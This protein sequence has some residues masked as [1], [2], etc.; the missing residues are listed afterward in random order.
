MTRTLPLLI[1]LACCAPAR[2]KERSP[3]YVWLEPEW[4]EGVKGSFT[5][6]TG[7]AKPTGAWGVAGPGVAAEWSQG[8]ESEWNSMGAPAAET[9]ARCERALVVPRAG[10][11]RLWVRYVD[12]RRKTEPFRV[13]IQQ[14]GK[15]VL[16]GEL[17]LKDVVPPGDEYQLYWG[18]S[19]AWDGVEG[20]LTEGPA[21]LALTIDKAGQGWRQ[22]DA[23]LLTDDLKYVPAGREKPAFAYQAGFDLR[24][25]AGA[26]WR[27]S[28]KGLAVGAGWKRQPPAGRDFAM[29]TGISPDPK[30]WAK[31]DRGR[32]TLPDVLYH[33]SP[34]A[35]IKDRFHKQFAGRKDVPIISWPKL[36]PG[37]YLGDTPDLSDG[38]PVRKWLERTKTPFFILTNYASGAYTDKTGPA[39]FAALTGPL[40]GQFLGYVHGE[41]VGTGGVALPE[42]PLAKDRR[43]HVD[44]LAGRLRKEQAA[45]WGK[46]YK[47]AVPEG[48]WDRGIS[49]LSADCIALAHLLHDAGSRTVG[50]EIDATNVHAPMRIAFARGAARQYGG[51]WVNY[52]S[53]NFGDSCNYFTQE[54]VVP[55]GAK[56]WFHSRYAVTDGVSIA[57][58][59]KLY[60]LN[61]LGGAAAVYWEQ[62][63]TNQYLL[64][65]PG[66]H[67]IQ[68]SPFGRATEDFQAFVDRLPD[69]GEPYT[70]VALLLSYGHGYDRVNYRCKMLN[71]FQEDKHDLELRELFN[72][73]WHPAG[74]LE[75]LPAS[76]DVQSMPAGAYGDIF[77]VLVDRP[78]RARAI[79]DYPV[80]WAAG[81]VRLTGP[82]QPVL[83]EY[84]QKGGTL[85]LNIEAAR[86]LPEKLLGLRPTGKYVRAEEWSPDGGNA[87]PTTPY[88]VARVDLAGARAL[89]WAG[90][91]Q[92]LIARHAV[93]A[94]AVIVTLVP[95]LIGL[96]ERAHPSIPFLLNGL[97]ERLLP[98][99]V[100]LADGRRPRGEV[101]Y[102]VN[103]TKDG[104]LVSLINPRGIDKT[105]N[106]IARVDRRAGV[107][108]V[109]STALP[110]R[111]A[112]EMTGPAGLAVRRQG[113][114]A[115]VPVR[116]PAG[117][118]RV[119]YLRAP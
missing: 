15:T 86:G 94:G 2:A 71:V 11:Y 34:P 38:S 83:E 59:R 68:L 37:F 104:Y 29:W 4:F 112:E 28:G 41:A 55:R 101:M 19:F 97:T 103:R 21:R 65:A 46:I 82:F 48:H 98:V 79:L 109:L 14:G 8:G 69:R 18:F 119:V 78:A 118:V 12:H 31:Q 50:Y 3:V 25:P 32:L 81:D 52:A 107:D 39:T 36:L 54:P 33:F 90:P 17:G 56:C 89:A 75:G 74:M 44:A 47:T 96:D 114:G 85:V 61:Y 1:V 102:Q 84:L 30:W 57:W 76:P 58:Y 93:G 23:L 10:K 87:R 45:A 80:V 20:T 77:D 22:V 5:Y 110:V 100:R 51:A 67:P 66:T 91:K 105:Q 92:P 16:A 99:E 88:E 64:P 9:S 42:Q 70:P 72:V 53:G 62:N 35:D 106:G 63:L 73:C 108:V 60:Y 113:S 95:H 117:D 115:T 13:S 49:C 24:P 40:A 43:G 27:G 7:T 111:S 116:V 26:S 6:W